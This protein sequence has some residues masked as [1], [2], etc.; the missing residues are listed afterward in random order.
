[1]LQC[2]KFRCYLVVEVLEQVIRVFCIRYNSVFIYAASVHLSRDRGH[3]PASADHDSLRSEPANKKI[4]KKLTI[5]LIL[6]LT[7]PPWIGSKSS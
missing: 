7:S 3:L 6:L 4:G 2:D 1:M 5:D